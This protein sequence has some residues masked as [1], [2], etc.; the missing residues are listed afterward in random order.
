MC[1]EPYMGGSNLPCRGQVASHE[2]LLNKWCG[3]GSNVNGTPS[4]PG[5][6]DVA[7]ISLRMPQKHRNTE[8]YLGNSSWRESPERPGCS[9]KKNS[10]RILCFCGMRQEMS[11]TSSITSW[12]SEACRLRRSPRETEFRLSMLQPRAVARLTRVI[13]ARPSTNQRKRE[14]REPVAYDPSSHL[15]VMSDSGGSVESSLEFRMLP[16]RPKPGAR[17]GTSIQQRRCRAHESFR[18]LFIETQVSI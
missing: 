13:G 15:S 1:F 10:V 12:P 8:M 14:R 4:S 5:S 11:V 17:I 3:R 16:F 7:D 18:S 9:N 2:A 6:L